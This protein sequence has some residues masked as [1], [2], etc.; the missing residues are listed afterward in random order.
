M[1]LIVLSL[2]DVQAQ[3]FQQPFFCQTVGIGLRFIGDGVNSGKGEVLDMHPGDF[4]VFN[5][6]EFD[7]ATGQFSG[8]GLPELVCDC[9]SLKAQF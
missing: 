8:V 5:L 4:R 9:S 2:F 3:Q 1:R 6:G 7:T